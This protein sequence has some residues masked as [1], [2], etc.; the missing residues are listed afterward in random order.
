M[1]PVVFVHFGAC[2]YAMTVTSHALRIG[3]EVI[4][5][6]DDQ[7]SAACDAFQ[8]GV[9]YKHLSTNHYAFELACF[10]RWFVLRDWMHANGIPDCLYCDTDVLL[11]CNVENEW[12]GDA[13]YAAHDFTLSMETS[14]H[15]SF[16]KLYALDAFCRFVWD[17]YSQRD[18]T[19]RELERIYG[20][21]RAGKLAGGVSDMLLLKM[22]MQQNTFR[23]GEMSVVRNGIVWD[24]NI[25]VSDGFYMEQGRKALHMANGVPRGTLIQH[26]RQVEFRSLHFQGGAKSLIPQYAYDAERMPQ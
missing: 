8:F 13:Y 10:E 12:H 1:I 7:L 9:H 14:G 5:L 26:A 3:N 19:F 2:E 24:H 17:T 23:V 18:A 21:M 4:L 11:F 22:F 6:G 16:W 20:A 25:N 15:T